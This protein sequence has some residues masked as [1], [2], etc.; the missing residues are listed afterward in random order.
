MVNIQDKNEYLSILE[1]INLKEDDED[2]VEEDKEDASEDTEN[3][4][5]NDAED[6]RD[7]D[8]TSDLLSSTDI[9]I[10]LGNLLKVK[11]DSSYKEKIDALEEFLSE[12]LLQLLAKK[13]EIDRDPSIATKHDEK[14]EA[15]FFEMFF[16]I[17]FEGVSKNKLAFLNAY[18]ESKSLEEKFSLVESKTDPL[19]ALFGQNVNIEDAVKNMTPKELEELKKKAKEM[20]DNDRRALFHELGRYWNKLSRSE[21][22]RT[23]LT[24]GLTSISPALG[25]V[26]QVLTGDL[27]RR[28]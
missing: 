27:F 12:V 2:K 8:D 26:S 23:A 3:A 21:V 19:V 22:G 7:E 15:D 5:D 6:F 28:R 10:A 16:D 20:N 1:S 25:F 9:K 4:S 14:G 18:L 11:L 24:A 13:K 17:I